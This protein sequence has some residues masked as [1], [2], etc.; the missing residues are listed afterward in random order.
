[1]VRM[2]Q[3]NSELPLWKKPVKDSRLEENSLH[4]LKDKIIK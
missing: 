1:M 3:E 2:F 4:Q